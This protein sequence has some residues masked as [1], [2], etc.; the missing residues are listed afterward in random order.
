MSAAA[1]TNWNWRTLENVEVECTHC[2]VDLYLVI[3]QERHQVPHLHLPQTQGDVAPLQFAAGLDD[4]GGLAHPPVSHHA[5]GE[6]G[7]GQDLL[8]HDFHLFHV[9]SALGTS[10]CVS[11]GTFGQGDILHA[12]LA[13]LKREIN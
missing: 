12:T 5:G 6:L 8:D 10:G 3:G 1:A 2:G 4:P 11:P 7:L 9:H 13:R